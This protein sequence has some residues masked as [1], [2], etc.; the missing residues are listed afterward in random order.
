MRLTTGLL[1]FALSLPSLAFA[2]GQNKS[3]VAP[4]TKS[5]KTVIK[6][7]MG[8]YKDVPARTLNSAKFA[9]FRS[10]QNNYLL[11]KMTAKVP[12]GA[13]IEGGQAAYVGKKVYPN[14]IFV[15]NSFMGRTMWKWGEQP[16]F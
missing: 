12:P 11:I 1:A 7:A 4:T 10:D 8:S 16:K 3:I 9:K 5:W 6:G 2:A 14:K 13:V 15:A